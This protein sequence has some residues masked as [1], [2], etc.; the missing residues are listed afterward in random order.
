MP[1]AT[2]AVTTATATTAAGPTASATA[3]M[4]AATAASA[5]TTASI[6]TAI[7]AGR[8]S[9]RRTRLLVGNIPV[10]VWLGFGF[11]REVSAA[12]DRHR[13]CG[14]SF[15]TFRRKFAA[16][17]LSALFFQNGLAGQPNAIA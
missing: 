12:F 4:T 9:V 11:I 15:G 13:R 7:T 3:V 17:H 14:S 8:T 2:A 16:T 1:A 6:S 10:E 5:A